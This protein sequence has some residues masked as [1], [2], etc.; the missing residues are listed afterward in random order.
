MHNF[1]LDGELSLIPLIKWISDGNVSHTSSPFCCPFIVIT[2]K[3]AI[4]KMTSIVEVVAWRWSPI[5]EVRCNFPMS[6]NN[7]ISNIHLFCIQ[8]LMH[9]SIWELMYKFWI[10]LHKSNTYILHTYF[11]DKTWMR[12]VTLVLCET[13]IRYT[14]LL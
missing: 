9:K 6:L 5:H 4:N 14:R 2:W 8:L 13:F 12:W 11:F 3:Q 10:C 7:R 1:C